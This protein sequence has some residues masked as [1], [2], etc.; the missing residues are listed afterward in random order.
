MHYLKKKIN[1]FLLLREIKM[2]YYL[3]LNFICMSITIH[4]LYKLVF[5]VIIYYFNID[6]Y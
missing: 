2:N 6:L 4:F 3:I 5:S 1:V